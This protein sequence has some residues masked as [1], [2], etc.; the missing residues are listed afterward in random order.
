MGEFEFIE[1]IK[2]RFE[3]IGDETIRG[4]GDDCAV[5]PVSETE[6]LVVTTDMLIEGVHFLRHATSARELGAKSL[7]VNL[8]DVAAMG[9]RPVASFLSIALPEDARGGGN[10]HSGGNAHGGWAEEFMEGYREMSARHGVA[11]AGGDTTASLSG[12][13]INVTVIGRAANSRLKFRSG[14]RAGDIVAVNGVLGESAAGLREILAGESASGKSDAGHKNSRCRRSDYAGVHRSPV[15]QVAEGE[16]LGGRTEVTAMMDL[17][18]GLASDLKHVLKASGAEVAAEG[19]GLGASLGASLGAR[20]ELTAVPVPRDLEFEDAVELAV[21]GGE[22]YKL[23][24]CVEADG[25]EALAADYRARFGKELYAVG[26]ITESWAKAL[27]K[28]SLPP[29]RQLKQTAMNYME[30]PS[31]RG[32]KASELQ[33]KPVIVWTENGTPVERDWKGFVHF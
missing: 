32:L 5:I 17:S 25:F 24:V 13:A 11:L 4:I 26:R 7:A 20:I 12:V 9:A 16:W 30:L 22:D 28:E 14:A 6:S 8:S 21:T 2:R 1:M 23:L 31:H 10:A 3:G 15:P 18:D 27:K 33:D 29:D 19:A